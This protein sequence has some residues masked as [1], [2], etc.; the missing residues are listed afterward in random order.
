MDDRGGPARGAVRLPLAEWTSP[1]QYEIAPGNGKK[2]R[3]RAGKVVGRGLMVEAGTL[4]L[5]GEIK[6]KKPIARPQ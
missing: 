6:K 4:I 2:D 1:L 5:K 3:S